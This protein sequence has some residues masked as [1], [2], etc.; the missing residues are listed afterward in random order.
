MQASLTKARMLTYGSATAPARYADGVPSGKAAADAAKATVVLYYPTMDKCADDYVKVR[1]TVQEIKK[2]PCTFPSKKEFLPSRPHHAPAAPATTKPAGVVWQEHKSSGAPDIHLQPSQVKGKHVHFIMDW[3]TLEMSGYQAVYAQLALLGYL[4]HLA[5]APFEHDRE[6]KLGD[7]ETLGINTLG[8]KWS[9]KYEEN[10]GNKLTNENQPA[11][12][13]VVVPWLRPCQQERPSWKTFGKKKKPFEM[14]GGKDAVEDGPQY[15][16]VPALRS[17]LYALLA[18]SP[19][20]VPLTLTLIDIHEPEPVRIACREMGEIVP[21]SLKF[22]SVVTEM[23]KMI[24]EGQPQNWKILLPDE[25]AYR[26]NGKRLKEL[27]SEFDENEPTTKIAFLEKKRTAEGLEQSRI[28]YKELRGEKGTGTEMNESEE[29]TW[30][31]ASKI[32]LIDDFSHGGGTLGGAAT[33]LKDLG[34]G[35]TLVGMLT[36]APNNYNQS[37]SVARFLN[38][39]ALFDK[40]YL[41]DTVPEV[42]KLIEEQARPS[43]TFHVLSRDEMYADI[44]AKKPTNL[45]V[46]GGISYNGQVEEKN[47]PL[48]K[49]TFAKILELD[50][51]LYKTFQ[52]AEIEGAARELPPKGAAEERN[53]ILRDAGAVM[54]LGVGKDDGHLSNL[55]KYKEGGMLVAPGPDD[56]TEEEMLDFAGR[57]Y[58]YCFSTLQDGAVAQDTALMKIYTG[59]KKTRKPVF[60]YQNTRK[61]TLKVLRDVANIASNVTVVPWATVLEIDKSVDEE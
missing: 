1:G 24:M 25:G 51:P 19:S 47:A 59:R 38:N 4:K 8:G 22:M 31:S 26:R 28:K 43:F 60:L 10:T 56:M 16:D 32:I 44:E 49:G 30:V 46:A 50:V 15:V 29:Q 3:G 34:P 48:Q 17:L 53:K 41:T 27:F 21:I 55:G 45:L 40:F 42:T 57:I 20:K 2:I 5:T 36:H 35:V 39:T 12:I 9:W 6:T 23:V 33:M 13:N 58:I 7:S 37:G 61:G 11:S 14:L 18:P 54:I 52:A